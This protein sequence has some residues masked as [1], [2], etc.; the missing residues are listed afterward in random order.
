M[1][2]LTFAL[3]SALMLVSGAGLY[4]AA[5]YAWARSSAV[6]QPQ[7]AQADRQQEPAT[8][9]V[10]VMADPRTSSKDELAAIS[11]RMAGIESKLDAMAAQAA[12]AE[13]VAPDD[14][15]GD[16]LLKAPE[17]RTGDEQRSLDAASGI[18]DAALSRGRW[19]DGDQSRM[20]DV[21]GDLLPADRFALKAKLAMAGNQGKLK[22]FAAR[23]FFF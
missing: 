18:V 1:R 11:G 20:R 13:Q 9:P 5:Q 22:D 21:V 15:G 10:F 7:P 17:S 8:R 23:P 4:A 6:E 14:R 3:L 2:R 12:H 16:V 19:V